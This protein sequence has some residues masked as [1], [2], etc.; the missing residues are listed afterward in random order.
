[1]FIYMEGQ[2]TINLKNVE[3]INVALSQSKYCLCFQMTSGNRSEWR[4]NKESER[5]KAYT[6]ILNNA[7]FWK[8]CE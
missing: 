7:F 4:F 5:D 6:Y 1:M 2:P 8:I 3:F